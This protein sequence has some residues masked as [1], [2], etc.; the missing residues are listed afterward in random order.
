MGSETLSVSNELTDT[1]LELGVG[2]CI[3]RG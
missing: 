2:D 3:W 1:L